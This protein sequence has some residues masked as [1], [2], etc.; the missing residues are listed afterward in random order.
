[1][2]CKAAEENVQVFIHFVDFT[3]LYKTAHSFIHSVILLCY[4]KSCILMAAYILLKNSNGF[5]LWI[6]FL[7]WSFDYFVIYKGKAHFK[8]KKSKT[9]LFSV[10]IQKHQVTVFV[11]LWNTF[12]S[13]TSLSIYAIPGAKDYR[14]NSCTLLE[15]FCV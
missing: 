7:L 9:G 15:R 3:F 1:M 2:V 4:L 8:Q 11:I 5:L 10:S 12:E 6:D 14:I 13:H